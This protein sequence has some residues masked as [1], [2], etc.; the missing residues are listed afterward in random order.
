[1][2]TGFSRCGHALIKGMLKRLPQSQPRAKHDLLMLRLENCDSLQRH[3]GGAGFGHL[4]V[5]LSM[6]LS[7]AIRSEDPVRIAAPGLFSV[8][9]KDR[10][11][12]EAMRIA[13]RL[14]KDA[15]RPATISG[16]TITPVFSGVMIHPSASSDATLAELSRNALFRLDSLAPNQ[17][18]AITLFDHDPDL[19]G[20]ELPASV[21]EAI[22]QNQI[23][24]YFQPQ[25]SCHTGLVTGFEALARWHHPS[26]GTLAPAAFMP[27]M[28]PQDHDQL[29]RTMLR[30]SIAALKQWDRA[31]WQVPTVS[32]NISNCELSDLHFA[33]NLL[34]ELDRQ[35]IRPDRLV[36]EVLE[37]VAPVTSTD[38]AR[39]NLACLSRAGCR[40]DLDDFG[41]G[42]ASLDAIR[43]FGVNRIKIDRSFVFG[44]DVDAAQQ[45]MILAILALAERLEISTLAE[46]V[47]NPEEQAFLAR[48]G[49]NEVQG[50]AIARPMPLAETFDFLGKQS[51]RV[52][53]RPPILKRN[54]G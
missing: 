7:R 11:E 25:I 50:Y 34:W 32:V 18:G 27:G 15:Q 53:R 4:L 3:L 51:T 24:P 8:I 44:C 19:Y 46:G 5:N 9:L 22:S 40:L 10:S 42:Y 23:V 30:Q 41:T 26:R 45:R 35:D 31:G 12:A 14:H 16:Q 39:E 2:W 49:C 54:F 52:D 28:T 6:R 37:S 29:T 33:Q 43:Q 38:T 36:L 48:I 17:M 21:S 47:E 1:M 20:P 13:Q